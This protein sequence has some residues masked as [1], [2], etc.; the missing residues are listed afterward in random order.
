[1]F[2]R[3]RLVL[4]GGELCGSLNEQN[5]QHAHLYTTAN[6]FSKVVVEFTE[7]RRVFIHT[8]LMQCSRPVCAGD[9]F[10]PALAWFARSF[11]SLASI[12]IYTFVTPTC[13]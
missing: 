12:H 8:A 2:F 1:M 4:Q 9:V 5:L 7:G 13:R 11:L 6:C 10:D 3:G